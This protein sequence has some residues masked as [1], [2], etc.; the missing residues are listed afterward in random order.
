[1]KVTNLGGYSY[2]RR[3]GD[4]AHVELSISPE[5]DEERIILLLLR[6]SEKREVNIATKGDSLH[7]GITMPRGKY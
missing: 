4:R 6:S 1:M 3:N 5:T 2:S 7:I